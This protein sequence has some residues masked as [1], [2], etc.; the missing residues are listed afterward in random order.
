[1]KT[2]PEG[3]RFNGRIER[4]AG[5]SEPSWPQPPKARPGAPNVI[6][7][8]LDDVGFAQ[9]GCYGSDIRTPHMDRLAAGG[10]M[11]TDAHSS[12]AVCTPQPLQ[13]PHG[14]LQLALVDEARRA[15]RV[16]AAPH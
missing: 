1:M 8:L 3:G 5:Q 12:S 16:L 4:T 11:F 7:F 10:M 15:E 2:Y 6:V 9:L 13:H 14:P